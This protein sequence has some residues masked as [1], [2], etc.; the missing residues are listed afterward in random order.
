MLGSPLRSLYDATG[1]MERNEDQEQDQGNGPKDPPK[2]PGD[3]TDKGFFPPKDD[4]E[5]TTKGD[6]RNKYE[7][8]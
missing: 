8:S 7:E 5:Y 6:D 2:D 4:G 3:V 1:G